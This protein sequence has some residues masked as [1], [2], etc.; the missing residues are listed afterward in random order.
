LLHAMLRAGVY[1]VPR[2]VVVERLLDIP[3]FE[4]KP[5]ALTKELTPERILGSRVLKQDAPPLYLA[6][7]PLAG[8]LLPGW[9]EALE[10]KPGMDFQEFGSSMLL[11]ERVQHITSM[12]GIDSVFK[13]L[14]NFGAVQITK[15]LLIRQ[16]IKE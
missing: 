11:A 12:G 7:F 3:Y 16:D 8:E 4:G 1:L 10:R 15:G 2:R 5:V 6:N 9:R 13:E 14:L